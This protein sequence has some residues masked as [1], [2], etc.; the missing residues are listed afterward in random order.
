MTLSMKHK[1]YEICQEN[2]PKKLDLVT[3]YH[4]LDRPTHRIGTYSMPQPSLEM[5]IQR[6][7]NEFDTHNT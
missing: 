6:I 5:G 3:E 2:N 1:S 4:E 7:K